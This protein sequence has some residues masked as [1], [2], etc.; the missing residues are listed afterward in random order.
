M[1]KDTKNAK[2]L[3]QKAC[4]R[5]NNKNDLIFLVNTADTLSNASIEALER[6]DGFEPF[7]IVDCG[8]DMDERDT[9]YLWHVEDDVVVVIEK[10]K[11]IWE[12]LG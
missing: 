3:A 1:I 7:K 6:Y 11:G 10:N 9:L 2:M 4:D 12:V 8:R 5:L